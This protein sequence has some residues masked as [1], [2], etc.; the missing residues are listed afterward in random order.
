[1][2]N[3][4]DSWSFLAELKRRPD[5]AMIPV[6]V[7]SHVD[8]PHKG[9]ALGANAYLLKPVDRARLLEALTRTTAAGAE[10]RILI[11]DDDDANHTSGTSATRLVPVSG[12]DST[13]KRPSSNASRSRIPARPIPP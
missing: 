5:T 3:G 1:M 11:V 2:V 7:A 4:E 12:P 10:R 6:V 13:V 8:D 9:Y